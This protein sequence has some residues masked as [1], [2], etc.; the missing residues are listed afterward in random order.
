LAPLAQAASVV[1]FNPTSNGFGSGETAHIIFTPSFSYDNGNALFVNGNQAIAN[2]AVGTGSTTTQFFFQNA[3]GTVNGSSAPG[4]TLGVN[5]NTISI[6][7]NLT[8][9]PPGP[10]SG[11]ISINNSNGG[12][13]LNLG[14]QIVLAGTFSERVTG[15]SP[16]G[17]NNQVQFADGSAA[18]LSATNS[19]TLY[20]QAA[21]TAN[22]LLGSGFPGPA[23]VAILQGHVIPSGFGSTFTSTFSSPISGTGSQTNPVTFD[24]Y[25]Y[26][27]SGGSSNYPGVKSISGTGSTNFQVQ[28]D[29]Y[30]SNYFLNPPTIIGLS[31]NPISTSLPFNAEPPAAK[32]QGQTPNIGSVN[33]GNL[34]PA[35]GTVNG[36]PDVM[37][38]T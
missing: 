19:V 28:V 31:F 36:G 18:V 5:N 38:Q 26:G 34:I 37:V 15:A 32:I 22:E 11:D 3:L 6:N 24:Q 13:V 30:N 16:S 14:S 2:F 25:S 33:G 21:G 7:S 20:I 29:S 23:A 27:M 1:E 10:T 35:L 8:S 4:T 12:Q 9:L 17:P